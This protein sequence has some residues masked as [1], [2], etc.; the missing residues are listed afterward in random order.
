MVNRWIG[1]S[2]DRYI[3]ELVDWWIGGSVDRY[4]GGW[5]Q[6]TTLRNAEILLDNIPISSLRVATLNG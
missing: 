5:G 2:V 6:F 1:G 4:I 3:G